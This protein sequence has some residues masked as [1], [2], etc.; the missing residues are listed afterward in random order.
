MRG[1]KERRAGTIIIMFAPGDTLFLR[2]HGQNTL[3]KSKQERMKRTVA[4]RVF[5]EALSVCKGE[6][7]FG[8]M[9]ANVKAEG[10]I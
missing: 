8:T 7:G 9:K 1:E 3:Y 4:T 5:K 10:A 6:L 2:T